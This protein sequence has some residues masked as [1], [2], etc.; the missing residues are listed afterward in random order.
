VQQQIPMSLNA[1]V[2]RGLDPRVHFF[3]NGLDCRRKPGN[4]EQSQ[5]MRKLF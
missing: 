4:D 5:C 3:R 1:I 2:T